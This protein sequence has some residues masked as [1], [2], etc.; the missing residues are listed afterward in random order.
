MCGCAPEG[1]VSDLVMA[2]EVVSS[3]VQ[4]LKKFLV[5]F[6]TVFIRQRCVKL[7]SFQVKCGLLLDPQPVRYDGA[8]FKPK[9]IQQEALHWAVIHN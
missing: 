8:W 6:S 9:T 7:A 1:Q 5:M 3:G 2:G 4:C